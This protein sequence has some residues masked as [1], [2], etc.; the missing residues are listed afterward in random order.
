MAPPISFSVTPT[1]SG[2]GTEATRLVVA[3]LFDLGIHRVSLE[4]YDFNPR[5]R[6]VY[7]KVGFTHEGTLRDALY[8]EG[9]WVDAHVMAMIAPEATRSE[10][11]AGHSES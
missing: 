6:H 8:W 1:L 3:H 5:A 4:V 7:E 9:E 2:I 10:D 11:S